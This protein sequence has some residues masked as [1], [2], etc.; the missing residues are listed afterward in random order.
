MRL[1]PLAVVGVVTCLAGGL[2]LVDARIAAT[3]D[4]GTVALTVAGGLAALQGARF[5]YLGHRESVAS[6]D[7]GNPDAVDA[8]TVLGD[9]YDALFAGEPTAARVDSF[10]DRFRRVAVDRLAAAHDWEESRAAAA[11]DDGS[12][13]DDPVAATFAAGEDDYPLV[14][15]ARCRLRRETP[16]RDGF[17]R[18]I[19]ELAA[20]EV[21]PDRSRVDGRGE[22]S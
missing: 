5:A 3:V 22:D 13:T 20:V 18:A 11:L 12:W 7:L 15:R 14:A 9:E 21:R 4:L 10:R 1:R 2:L 19:R 16:A 6:V 17:R 8:G